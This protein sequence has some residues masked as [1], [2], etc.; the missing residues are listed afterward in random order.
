[1]SDKKKL[2]SV[3][4]LNMLLNI[5]KILNTHTHFFIINILIFQ[6]INIKSLYK[7]YIIAK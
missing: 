2:W 6:I 5:I 3:S 1:M 7:N 4:A